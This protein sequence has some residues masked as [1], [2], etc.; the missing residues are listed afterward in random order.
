MSTEHYERLRAERP[1]CSAM[2]PVASR[3]SPT[4]R[5]SQPRVACC[6]RTRTC[7]CCATRSLSRRLHGYVHPLDPPYTGARVR[8]APAARWHSGI[9]RALPARHPLLAVGEPR[10]LG[11]EG[12]SAEDNAAKE[13]LEE[14]G[15]APYEILPLGE[16]HPD[17]GRTADR[18]SLFAARIEAVGP[19]GTAEESGVACRCRSPRRRR[20]WRTAGSRTRSRSPC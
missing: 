3:S 17:T 5:R 1:T 15:A 13:L 19:L 4:R 2:S 14:I 8:G 10:G 6:T 20:W 9:D 11:T 7:C 12:L 16:L 18:V